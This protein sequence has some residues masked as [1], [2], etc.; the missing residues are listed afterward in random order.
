M[1]EFQDT[2]K[3][4]QLAT[5]IP[6]IGAKMTTEHENTLFDFLFPI[7]Q[8]GHLKQGE[9]KATVKF[10]ANAYN[11]SAYRSPYEKELDLNKA[12]EQHPELLKQVQQ[13]NAITN[14]QVNHTT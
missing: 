13:V 1:G 7:L 9:A 12:L 6:L 8:T 14:Q 10:L 11:D 4:A 3:L 2:E 5:D